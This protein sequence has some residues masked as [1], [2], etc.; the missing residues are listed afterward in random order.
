MM[1][2]SHFRSLLHETYKEWRNDNPTVLAASLSY[3]ALFA[4]VPTL[5]IALALAGYVF[6]SLMAKRA[7]LSDVAIWF[8]PEVASSLQTLMKA[9][10]KF[11]LRGTF[12]SV[13][14]LLWAS[15]RMFT[16]LQDALNMVWDVQVPRGPVRWLKSRFRAILMIGALSL[17]IFIFVA[18][19]IGFAFVK[20]MW[21]VTLPPV[22]I[23]L[24]VSVGAGAFSLLLFTVLFAMVYKVLPERRI[25][26]HDVWVGAGVSS[27]LFGAERWLLALYFL[28]SPI[29]SLYGAAGSVLILLIWLYFSMQILIFGASFT[30][31]YSRLPRRPHHFDS[32]EKPL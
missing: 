31:A 17:V 27:L 13:G 21:L 5:V 7:L 14:F 10:H 29:K 8:A 25:P 26:W 28:H 1:E 19:D 20:K 22:F 24:L 12:L 23:R 32:L 11:T 30:R 16:Q 15:M 3:F 4:L 9:A 6:E 18:L 2:F